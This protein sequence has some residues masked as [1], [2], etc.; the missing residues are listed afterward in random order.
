MTSSKPSNNEPPL[1]QH[2]RA[3]LHEVIFEADTP[4]GKR[5]D[6]MLLVAIVLSVMAVMLESVQSIHDEWG[7]ELNIAEWAFTGLF[8]IE[9]IARLIS[10]K[11]PLKYAISFFGVVDLLSIL[12]TFLT[13]FVAGTGSLMVVRILRLLR[14]FRVL[15]LIKFI[16]EARVLASALRASRRKVFVFLITVLSLVVI[17]GTF[18]YIIEDEAAGFTSIPRSIYWAVVT[19]TTVGYGDIAP[20]SPFGQFLASIIMILGYSIL[21]VPTGIVGNELAKAESNFT[22]T[23]SCGSCSREGH[24]NDAVF[25]KFCGEELI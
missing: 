7:K 22:N 6:I 2:W 20:Q 14:I 13:L 23:Q 25:C 12:P 16:D 11:K 5:F 4:L 1:P 9:Y 24:A 10:I 17:L 21:A 18:M 3:K 8:T 15:K 19:L